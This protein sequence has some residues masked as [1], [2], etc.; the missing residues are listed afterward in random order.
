ME[1]LSLVLSYFSILSH[2]LDEDKKYT[3][4]LLPDDTQERELIHQMSTLRSKQ[5]SEGTRRMARNQ[6]NT[7]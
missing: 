1:A 7:I 2:L 4:L 5:L 6:E 3:L